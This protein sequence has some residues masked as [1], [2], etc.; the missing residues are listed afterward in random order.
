V[1]FQGTRGVCGAFRGYRHWRG[2]AFGL[3]VLYTMIAMGGD[4]RMFRHLRWHHG[5][6]SF[7]SAVEHLPRPA[8]GE[9]FAFAMRWWTRAS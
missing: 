1:P 5:A 7:A 3:L 2:P 8:A 4:L 9:K 6:T